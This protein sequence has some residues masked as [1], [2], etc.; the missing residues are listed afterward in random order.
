MLALRLCIALLAL[1]VMAQVPTSDLFLIDL[2]THEA[3]R[4]PT[5][6]GYNNQPSFLPDGRLLFAGNY[7]DQT[8][9][10]IAD[11]SGT[12]IQQ[13]TFSQESEYSPTLTPDGAHISSVRV[14]S[15]GTQRLWQFPL[16][17]GPGKVLLPHVKGVGYHLWVSEQRLALFIVGTPHTLVLGSREGGPTQILF[18]EPGRCLAQVPGTSMFSVMRNTRKGP[19]LVLFSR[20]D[21]LAEKS[22][23]PL[24]G[25]QDYCWTPAGLLLMGSGSE[26]HQ[27]DSHQAN[28]TWSLRVDLASKDIGQISRMAVSPDGKR[29]ALVS[30]QE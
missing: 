15:D 2:T 9:L 23:E 11:A 24:E 1:P 25:A 12:A 21:M 18:S 29:L 7:D 26:L 16:E 5:P 17:G 20:N 13:L 6:V 30:L 4:L 27:L 28:G 22:L 3:R 14:E 19:R 10:Y 8:D